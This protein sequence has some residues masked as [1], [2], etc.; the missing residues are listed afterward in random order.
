M[1][2]D[3]LQIL[4]G[5]GGAIV[6]ITSANAFR[7][8]AGYAPYAASKHGVVGLTKSAAKEYAKLG[9]RINAVCPGSVYTPMIE[10]VDGGPPTPESW[11]ITRAP[12]GRIGN[13]EE[14]ANAVVWLCS[15]GASYVTGQSLVVDGG[16][17][18]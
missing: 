16:L 7:G 3:I 4:K 2:Y 10:R 1:K 15:N 8:A 11:R 14:I 12:M 18:A 5:G 9:I 6:N 13:P 17:L